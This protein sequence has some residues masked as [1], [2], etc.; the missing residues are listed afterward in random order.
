MPTK[1]KSGAKRP[2]KTSVAKDTT[3]ERLPRSQR[4][5]LSALLKKFEEQLANKETRISVADYIRLLQLKRE[6]E[7]DRVRDVK[8]TWVEQDASE[9]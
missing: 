2:T 4:G 6:L 5:K 1:S 9:K 3:P 7:N 8:V